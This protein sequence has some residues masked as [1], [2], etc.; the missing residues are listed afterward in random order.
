MIPFPEM[1]LGSKPVKHETV[2][3]QLTHRVLKYDPC[4]AI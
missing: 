2:P 3:H 1:N 4:E